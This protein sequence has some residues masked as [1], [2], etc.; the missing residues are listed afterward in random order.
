MKNRVHTRSFA[1]LARRLL[2]ASLPHLPSPPNL[3]PAMT[4][5]DTSTLRPYHRSRPRH[6]ATIGRSFLPL[7]ALMLFAGSVVF[8]SWFVIFLCGMGW[9]LVAGV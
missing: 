6:L 7:V 8:A 9:N 3:P 2:C 5:N 1:R 4:A